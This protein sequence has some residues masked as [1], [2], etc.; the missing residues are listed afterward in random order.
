MMP[1]DRHPLPE[2]K[3]RI[4]LDKETGH[5]YMTEPVLTAQGPIVLIRHG[6]TDANTRHVLQGVSD[7]GENQLNAHG[8]QQAEKA[9]QT[10][11][12]QLCD[13]YGVTRGHQMMRTGDI[14]LLASPLGRAK[15]TLDIFAEHVFHHT[16]CRVASHEQA[17][18]AEMNFGQADG[19]S[20]KE[21]QR[22]GLD[23]LVKTTQ[24][25]RTQHASIKFDGG[26]SFLDVLA[27][28]AAMITQINTIF[29]TGKATLCLVFTHGLVTSALRAIVGD[30]SILNAHGQIDFRGKRLGHAI[31]HW[32]PVSDTSKG[33]K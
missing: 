24:I 16:G 3:N 13:R 18:L 8:T 23:H 19:L 2:F 26:E 11:Y 1:H 33:P 10:L 25:Y 32:L 27:R 28:S 7:A 5:I 29:A 12:A 4:A 31:P 21:M 6:E 20:V 22:A 14:M 15:A 17:L 30:P 9:A